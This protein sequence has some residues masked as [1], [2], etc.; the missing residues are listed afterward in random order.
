MRKIIFLALLLLP[1]IMS[2][3]EKTEKFSFEIGGTLIGSEIYLS[4]ISIDLINES[5]IAGSENT[6]KLKASA[7]AIK[8]INSETTRIIKEFKYIPNLSYEDNRLIY[9]IDNLC[10]KID[11]DLE[12][13]I[14][15]LDTQN[16]SDY[17]IFM[18]KHKEVWVAINKLIQDK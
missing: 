17:M 16:N 6:D 15:Y 9:Q 1:I 10:Q 11:D 14:K 18:D 8:K 4:Y 12:L 3:K 2:A 13:L 7:D 5:I